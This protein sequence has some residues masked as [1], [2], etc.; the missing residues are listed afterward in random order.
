MQFAGNL[1]PRPLP[2]VPA[3]PRSLLIPILSENK[4]LTLTS[5]LDLHDAST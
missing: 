4:Q 3:R 2:L 1:L 5:T